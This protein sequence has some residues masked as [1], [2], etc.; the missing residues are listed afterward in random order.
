MRLIDNKYFEVKNNTPYSGP[1]IDY[2]LNGEKKINGTIENGTLTGIYNEYYSTGQISRIAFFKAGLLE[3][4]DRHFFRN[5]QL[6]SSVENFNGE[7]HGDWKIYFENGKLSQHSTF[8]KGNI[9]GKSISFRSNGDT[10]SIRKIVNGVLRFSKK[11]SKIAD[12]F[13]TAQQLY[14]LEKY[15]LSKEKCN[16]IIELDQKNV[17]ALKLKSMIN[18]A[19]G[20]SFEAKVDLDKAISIEPYNPDLYKERAYLSLES[21]SIINQSNICS[22]LLKFVEYSITTYWKVFNLI[23]TIFN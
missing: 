18:K 13:R 19:L 7:T 8:K 5:G 17:S 3:G 2:Y 11:E 23:D 16:K 6:Y 20:K 22:D 14:E 9:Y 4:K 12:L 15:E 10:L 21:D 1:F